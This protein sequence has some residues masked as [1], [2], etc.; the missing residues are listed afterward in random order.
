MK[1]MQK[2][3]NSEMTARCSL[4]VQNFYLTMEML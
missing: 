2:Q 1:Q 4:I 3:K